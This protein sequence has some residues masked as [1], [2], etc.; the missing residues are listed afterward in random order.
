MKIQSRVNSIRSPAE[1]EFLCIKEA[2]PTKEKSNR[3][4]EILGKPSKIKRKKITEDEIEKAIDTKELKGIFWIKK[5]VD[6]EIA[7]NKVVAD[8]SKDG[9]KDEN[10]R[11]EARFK[12][13]HG[14]FLKRDQYVK[15]EV[16][17]RIE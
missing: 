9:W 15:R 6:R 5:K 12:Q 4:A 2:D 3:I 13:L 11:H 8:D 1:L 14:D 7:Q 10:T 17:T 16:E